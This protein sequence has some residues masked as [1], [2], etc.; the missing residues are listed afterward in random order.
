MG[1]HGEDPF[2]HL[3]QAGIEQGEQYNVRTPKPRLSSRNPSSRNARLMIPLK[4]EGVSR[5]TFTNRP[6]QQ[7]QTDTPPMEKLLGNLKK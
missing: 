5:G 1:V 3:H 7:R 2:E 4:T 6:Q